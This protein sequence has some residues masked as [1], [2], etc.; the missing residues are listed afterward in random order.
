[1]SWATSSGSL[2]KREVEARPAH[3]SAPDPCTHQGP[4]RSRTL[5]E[6]GLTRRLG[7]V[8]RGPVSF[9]GAPALL[10]CGVSPCH[11]A[12]FG[13]PIQRGQAWSSTRP[14][15]VAWV[16]C[17]HDVGEGTPDLG[18]RQYLFGVWILRSAL[19]RSTTLNPVDHLEHLISKVN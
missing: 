14:G 2:P 1:M 10:G 17:L 19:L 6:F 12:S 8:Y 5:L 15:D 13:L 11:V 9:C 18:Y 7:L 4:S 3:V 16:R